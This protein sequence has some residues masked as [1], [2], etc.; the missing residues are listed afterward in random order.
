MNPIHMMCRTF[1]L[2]PMESYLLL[3]TPRWAIGAA[4]GGSTFRRDV[5]ERDLRDSIAEDDTDRAE[6]LS[7]INRLA[8]LPLTQIGWY[9]LGVRSMIPPGEVIPR[10]GEA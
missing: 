7:L 6:T 5:I 8:L 9:C 10:P 2:L 4:R 3:V 1:G